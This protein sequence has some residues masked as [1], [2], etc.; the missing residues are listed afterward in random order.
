M[1]IREG[2]SQFGNGNIMFRIYRLTSPSGKFYIGLTSFDAITRFKR[3]INNWK[4]NRKS[5]LYAAFNKYPPET[6]LVESIYQSEFKDEIKQKEKYYIAYYNTIENGYNILPGGELSRFGVPHTD[7]AK[8][9]ISVTSSRPRKPF[10]D[11]WKNNIRK[12]RLGTKATPETLAKLKLRT[13]P[14][15]GKHHSEETKQKLRKNHRSVNKGIPRTQEIKNKISAKNKGKKRTEQQK[16]NVRQA[17]LA[18]HKARK[19]QN[20]EQDVAA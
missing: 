15:L 4:C 1:L 2:I 20:S 8:Q 14:M 11:E 16:S 13:P 5:K 6:W 10:S 19:E 12:A 7:E 3:H 18:Y 17:L 9:K